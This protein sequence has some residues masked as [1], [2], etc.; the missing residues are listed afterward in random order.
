MF[1]QLNWIL[2]VSQ[3]AF[4]A[5]AAAGGLK[6][7]TPLSSLEGKLDLRP[8]KHQWAGISS[9]AV[10][11]GPVIHETRTQWVPCTVGK[12]RCHISDGAFRPAHRIRFLHHYLMP[13]EIFQH[14]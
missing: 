1:S 10:P 2:F 5:R 14:I 6:Q 8:L 13:E 4:S 3:K 9:P 11:G 7:G 12:H